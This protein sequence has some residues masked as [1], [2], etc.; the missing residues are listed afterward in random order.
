[1]QLEL[2][3]HLYKQDEFDTLLSESEHICTQRKE[4]TEKLN[5]LQR[6]SLII[7][8]ICETNHVVITGSTRL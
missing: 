6:A 1:M 2:V 8:E 4:A 7:G 5:A 3:T